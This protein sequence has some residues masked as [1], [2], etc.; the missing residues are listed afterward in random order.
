MADRRDCTGAFRR[1]AQ[2]ECNEFVAESQRERNA[3]DDPPRYQPEGTAFLGWCI[4]PPTK[5]GN[6]FWLKASQ[7]SIWSTELYRTVASRFVVYEKR[8]TR[9]HYAD[10]IRRRGYHEIYPGIEIDCA[11]IGLRAC[12]GSRRRVLG[13][14]DVELE[15]RGLVGGF[16]F[17]VGGLVGGFAFR[18]GGLFRRILV[19]F[20]KLCLVGGAVGLGVVFGEP[21]GVVCER[22]RFQR[23]FRIFERFQQVRS[24]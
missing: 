23:L 21:G 6:P 10:R 24:L 18:V 15:Q 7:R 8:E 20:R 19:F 1:D 16:A 14:N 17:R 4:A 11:R 22:L 13:R 2:S 3:P 5:G 12:S 9:Y